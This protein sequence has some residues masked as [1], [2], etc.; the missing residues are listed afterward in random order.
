MA[1][2]RLLRAVSESLAVPSFAAETAQLHAESASIGAGVSGGHSAWRSRVGGLR[3]RRPAHSRSGNFVVE[4]LSSSHHVDHVH[5]RSVGCAHGEHDLHDAR[6]NSC[7][8]TQFTWVAQC[9][10]EFRETY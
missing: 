8:G 3:M 5:T 1:E 2:T 4:S 10:R 9:T 6:T 7:S